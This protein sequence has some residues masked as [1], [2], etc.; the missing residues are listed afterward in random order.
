MEGTRVCRTEEDFLDEEESRFIA[1]KAA[2]LY[3][4]KTRHLVLHCTSY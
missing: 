3:Q 4:Y 2:C 1:Q